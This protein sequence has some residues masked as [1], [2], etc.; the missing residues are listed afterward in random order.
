MKTLVFFFLFLFV[1]SNQFTIDFDEPV[2][3]L[4]TSISSASFDSKVLQQSSHINFSSNFRNIFNATIR[5]NID[6]QLHLNH[7][8]QQSNMVTPS[9][10]TSSPYE[11]FSHHILKNSHILSKIDRLQFSF[12]SDGFDYVLG[13]QAISFGTSHFISVMDV[14]NPFAPGTIDSSFKPGID[15]L[16]IQKAMSD[17]GEIE[18]IYAANQTN[19]DNAYFLRSR[20]L[21]NDIDYELIIG[22]FRKHNMIGLGFEGEINSQSVWGELALIRYDDNLLDFTH[23]QENHLSLNLGLDFHPNDGETISLSWFHQGSG[24]RNKH[25]FNRVITNPSFKEQF[26]YLKGKNYLN[27]TYQRKI[28]PLVDFSSAIIFNLEDSSRFIQPQLHINTSDNSSL[29]IFY[30]FGTGKESTY[31]TIGDDFGDLPQTIGL[32]SQVY[33]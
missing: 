28:K 11:Q 21:L 26:S 27:I 12:E 29:V 33:F 5:E 6:F 24:A 7:R 31:T 8:Y 32:F 3:S 20:L 10:A 17:T 9:I 14:I 4:R 15:G 19:K 25:D 22:R 2:H 1:V 18:F 30:T 13:R 23:N 16:R